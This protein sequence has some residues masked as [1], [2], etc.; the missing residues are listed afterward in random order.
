M[1]PKT[2]IL[3]IEDEP[4]MRANLLTILKMEGFEA[5]EGKNGRDGVAV[6]QNARP[7][8]IFCDISMPEMD[9]HAVLAALRANPTTA[10]IPFVFLTAR[11]GAS[12]VRSGMNLGADDYLVKPVEVDDLLA[13]ITSRLKRKEQLATARRP[14]PEPSPAL[15]VPMGLTEREAEVLFWLSQGKT[16]PEL[17]VLLGVQ[18]TT[19]KKHLE[20][21]FL[22]LGVE[23]RTS[24]A[25]MALEKMNES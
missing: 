23:N 24:A 5:L 6:A 20:S 22:K 14:R 15:L 2:R 9:G 7:D 11:G 19:I 12:D 13:A 16:N 3:V 1:T 21:I 17:C 25:A 10:S 4:R 8:V 18:L